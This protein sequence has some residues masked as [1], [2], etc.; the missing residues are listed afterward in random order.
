MEEGNDFTILAAY[1][2]GGASSEAQAG[3]IPLLANTPQITE[4]E[5]S[6][7]DHAL[8][9]GVAYCNKGNSEMIGNLDGNCVHTADIL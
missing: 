1:T 5:H 4:A 8:G 3:V 6:N 7:R 9:V 2:R